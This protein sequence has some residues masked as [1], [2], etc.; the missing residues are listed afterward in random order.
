MRWVRDLLERRRARRRPDAVVL[1]DVTSERETA[2]TTRAERVEDSTEG[3]RISESTTPHERRS[4]VS[5]VKKGET[6]SSRRTG[7]TRTVIGFTS[8]P[9]GL[10]RARL[11]DSGGNETRVRVDQLGRNY[12]LG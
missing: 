3:D 12:T 5:K 1:R 4:E 9:D 11:I 7:K 10:R 2:R 8:K 6:L